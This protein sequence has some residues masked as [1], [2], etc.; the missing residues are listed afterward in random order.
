MGG[1]KFAVLLCA[2]DSEYVKK[3]YGGYF[4]V[5]VRMLGRKERHGMFIEWLVE[6]FL[7]MMRL[8]PLMVRELPPE[9]EVI[10]WSDKT[11]I[12]MFRYEDHI[13]GI[14]GH[15]EYNKDILSHLVSTPPP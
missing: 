11:G 14:Q 10:A 7:M 4:G 13:M 9:A 8:K 5:F 2:E 6:S 3:K 1:K 12:E 15:P